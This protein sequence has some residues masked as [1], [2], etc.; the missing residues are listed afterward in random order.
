M[1]YIREKFVRTLIICAKPSFEKSVRTFFV[2]LAE[3][4]GDIDIKYDR[5]TYQLKI[6]LETHGVVPSNT[7]TYIIRS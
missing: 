2:Y 3:I 1:K 5:I 7:S 4:F 6:H